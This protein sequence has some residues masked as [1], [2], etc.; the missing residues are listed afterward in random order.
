MPAPAPATIPMADAKIQK[1]PIF[2]VLH[3]R[4]HVY[5]EQKGM[6]TDVIR[7]PN[8]S[9]QTLDCHV[10]P[11]GTLNRGIS[12]FHS[13]EILKGRPHADEYLMPP[14]S[15]GALSSAH[16]QAVVLFSGKFRIELSGLGTMEVKGGGAADM[17]RVVESMEVATG[18]SGRTTTPRTF[19]E[20]FHDTT[21]QT[22]I[23]Q[24]ID[25]TTLISKLQDQEFVI[26]KIASDAAL[27]PPRPALP[28]A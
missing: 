3:D 4:L 28:P 23:G 17:A 20:A 13:T 18:C 1:R 15:P 9:R 6:S 16:L 2:P 21:F 11:G 22:E 5:L 12:F 26:Y 7:H 25:F 10:L 27:L 24:F 8:P 14:S 19:P